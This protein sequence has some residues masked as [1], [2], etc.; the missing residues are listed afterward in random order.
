MIGE[1]QPCMERGRLAAAPAQSRMSALTAS[2][3]SAHGS[4]AGEA[5][6][7]LLDQAAYEMPAVTFWFEPASHLQRFS[8]TIRFVGH[9]TDIDG[10][11]HS[12][13]RLVP[14][15]PI[16]QAVPVPGT[17]PATVTARVPSLHPGNRAGE[18]W[19]AVLVAMVAT[20]APNDDPMY[21]AA[22]GGRHWYGYGG[23]SVTGRWTHLACGGL[24]LASR[25]AERCDGCRGSSGWQTHAHDIGGPTR[26]LSRAMI[27]GHWALHPS[28]GALGFCGV[29]AVACTLVAVIRWQVHSLATSWTN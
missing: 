12:G 23:L 6:A 3:H 14:D 17:G 2:A 25:A 1:R 15:E 8:V 24:W 13:D 29:A 26:S 7:A 20:A 18:H 4:A 28:R 5:C 9:R 11:S 16:A 27:S 22:D 10:P 19:S 21:R